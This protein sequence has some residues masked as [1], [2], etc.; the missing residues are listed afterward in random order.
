MTTDPQLLPPRADLLV[1][2][3]NTSDREVGALSN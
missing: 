3:L 1:H 2:V